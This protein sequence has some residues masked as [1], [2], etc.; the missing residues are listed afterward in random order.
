MAVVGV[1]SVHGVLS[2]LFAVVVILSELL[3]VV[4]RVSYKQKELVTCTWPA[5][6]CPSMQTSKKS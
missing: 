2:E 3:A 5:R 6:S 1:V 4:R